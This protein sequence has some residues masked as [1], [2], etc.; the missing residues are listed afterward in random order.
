MKTLIAFILQWIEKRKWKSDAQ[1]PTVLYAQKGD[2]AT[3]NGYHRYSTAHPE[4]LRRFCEGLAKEG[5]VLVHTRFWAAAGSTEDEIF[6][7]V[8]SFQRQAASYPQNANM[9][10]WFGLHFEVEGIVDE[11]FMEAARRVSTN[12]YLFMVEARD[13]AKNHAFYAP[14]NWIETFE[15]LQEY[16]EEYKG[17]RAKLGDKS[18]GYGDSIEEWM[19]Y[20]P[21]K[22]GTIYI[23]GPY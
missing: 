1:Y 6:T 23:N 2:E 7:D 3:Y 5:Q 11:A 19:G 13:P 14:C 9:N 21:N 22:N 15:E 12:D 4:Y 20:V 18:I 10:L 17:Y 8:E 16:M